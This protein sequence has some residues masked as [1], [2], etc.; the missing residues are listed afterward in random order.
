MAYV[1]DREINEEDSLDPDGYFECQYVDEEG[2]QCKNTTFTKQNVFKLASY[3]TNDHYIEEV[4][5]CAVKCTACGSIQSIGVDLNT[6]SYAKLM[7]PGAK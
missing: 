1:V 4:V 2:V 7:K 5:D 3:K 6:V